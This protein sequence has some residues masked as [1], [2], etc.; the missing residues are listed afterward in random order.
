MSLAPMAEA[1]PQPK[2]ATNVPVAPAAASAQ[3]GPAAGASAAPGPGFI[4]VVTGPSGAGKGTLVSHLLH[5]RPNCV[6]S[7]SATTRARRTTESQGREYEF[8]EPAEFLTRMEKGYFLEWANVHGQFYGTP[9]GPV[10]EQ[11]RAGKVV[12]LDVDVQ[13][14]ASVRRVRPRASWTKAWRRGGWWCW[15]WTCRAE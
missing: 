15:T 9:V 1:K 4:L 2:P 5:V 6:F 7:V 13:G 12:V 14:G 11:V 3:G 8:L 10:D